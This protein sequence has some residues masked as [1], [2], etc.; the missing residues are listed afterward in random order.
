[1]NLIPAD[2]GRPVADIAN[3]YANDNL[4]RDCQR[5]LEDL[6]P[7]ERELLREGGDWYIRRV[8]PYRT[9]DNRIEGTVVTFSD[10]TAMKRRDEEHARLA[11]IVDS[12]ENA[13]IG[14][15]PDG[16][17]TSWN[18][19]AEA[20]YGYR[21]DEMIGQSLD[22]LFPQRAP[23]QAARILEQIRGGH[24]VGPYETEGLH[25]DGT[26]VQ[27]SVSVSPIHDA[28]GRVIAASTIARD[29]SERKQAERVLLDADRR[30]N[31]FLAIL[32][33]ELRNPLTPIRH[34]VHVLGRQ[35][36]L[37]DRVRWAV[38]LIGRQSEQLERLVNDLVDVARITEGHIQLSS[39]PVDVQRALD[40][41]LESVAP[42]ARQAHQ[43]L[44]VRRPDAPVVV[45]ADP[46]RLSQVF[47]NLLHNAVKYT[48]DGGH[49]VVGL[50]Q[51]GADAVIR[52]RDDGIGIRAEDFPHLFD[53]FSRGESGQSKLVKPDGLG[54]GLALA[55]QLS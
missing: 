35:G 25:K 20:T 34:A 52:V 37:P 44:E 18:P 24:R 19:G 49:I 5:V 33:H 8:Q 43:H 22:P 1:M 16:I 3:K 2:I 38:D 29:I 50:Q 6:Q 45:M 11:S 10:V 4:T 13:I 26:R 47:A 55:K 39:A 17:I 9:R 30:K 7:V 51:D 32:G 15:T 21:A 54:V 46:V 40:N 48:P 14:M 36:P 41:A 42:L 12:T 53:F 27:L 28:A 31:E 23:E